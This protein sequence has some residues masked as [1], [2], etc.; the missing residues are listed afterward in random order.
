L[1]STAT[2]DSCSNVSYDMLWLL[3]SEHLR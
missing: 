1:I 2:P 3:I